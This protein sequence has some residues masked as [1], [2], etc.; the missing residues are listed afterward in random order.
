[1]T[2]MLLNMFIALI[3]ATFSDAGAA[4]APGMKVKPEQCQEFLEVWT[5]VDSFG[6]WLPDS[7]LVDFFLLVPPPLGFKGKSRNYV[8]LAI[9]DMDMLMVHRVPGRGSKR[10]VAFSELL[11]L[12]VA[13]VAAPRAAL[14]GRDERVRR[15]RA[16]R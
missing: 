12:R 13:G 7:S 11:W 4:D 16:R 6:R 8:Q 2:F 14:G 10:H 9:L 15:V 3:M 5:K 1:M